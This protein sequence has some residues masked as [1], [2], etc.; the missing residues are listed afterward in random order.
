[1]AG[2]PQPSPI[3]TF[4][5]LVT[6]G[7]G[8]LGINLIRLL[9]ELGWRG[10]SLDI[11]PFDYPERGRVD[12][13]LGDIRDPAAVEHAMDGVDIVVHCA[14]ALPLAP[15]AEI[16]STDIQGTRVL[17]EAA[18][19]HRVSRFVFVSSTA[20]YGIPDHHPIREED[21]LHGVGPY[22]LAKVAAEQVCAE[23]RSRGMCV[24]V[25]RP[26][27]FVGPERLGVFEL[28]YDWAFDGRRFPVLGRGDNLYQLLDVEDLCQ[29]IHLCM[30]RP[31]EQVNDTFNVA[32]RQFGSMRDN[33][34]TVLDRAGHGKRVVSLPAGPAVL[35]LRV[36]EALGLSPMY[37]WIYE[38]AG[39]DSFVAIDRLQTRLGFTPRYSNR[40]AL[41]RN[42][43][44]YVAH[45]DE[46]RGQ[47][48]VTHRVP[49]KRGVLGIAKHAF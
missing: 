46:F 49:W 32:A 4:S 17:L 23:Y 47:H 40:E 36:L 37:S 33:V 7:S 5:C 30:T 21:P 11:A 29:V 8:F 31:V 6:G 26:K 38:T 25:L 16:L 18:Q 24:S 43:D 14:A 2:A 45:R 10:R 15:E 9:L 42:Y 28:L 39:R 44:W 20:V 3:E 48:G 41:V 12:A 19:R 34:Q 27:S 13:I 35:I 22:G 1:M